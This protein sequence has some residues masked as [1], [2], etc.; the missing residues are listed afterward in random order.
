MAA[1]TMGLSTHSDGEIGFPR[2]WLPFSYVQDLICADYSA[3]WLTLPR[4][5]ISSVQIDWGRSD[6][7]CFLRNILLL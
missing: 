3:D 1:E 5:D 6:T 4:Q 2:K 7:R